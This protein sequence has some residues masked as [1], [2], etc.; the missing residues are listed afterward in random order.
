MNLYD[1]MGGA[2]FYKYSNPPR[3]FIFN[4]PNAG[5]DYEEEGMD[6]EV[7]NRRLK[8]FEERFYDEAKVVIR[9]AGNGYSQFS[10]VAMMKRWQ[11]S[12]LSEMEDA[13][14]DANIGR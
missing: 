6:K 8:D 10:A 9:W 1:V 12:S 4:D 13:G 2:I 3:F 5:P 14:R 7:W 11:S